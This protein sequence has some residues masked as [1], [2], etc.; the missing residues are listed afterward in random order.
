MFRRS[1]PRLLQLSTRT[2]PPNSPP[3]PRTLVVLHGL[4]G[5]SQN[6]LSPTKSIL[7]ELGPEWSAVLLDIRGHGT[8]PPGSP[9]TILDAASDV[10]STLTSLSISPTAV[11]GHSLGGKIALQYLSISPSPPLKTWSLDSF[12][13]PLPRPPPIPGDN[14]VASILSAV[15]TCPRTFSSKSDLI[16]TLTED[17]LLQPSIAMWM[18]TNLKRFETGRFE[19]TFDVE[20]CNNLYD[21]FTV[22]DLTDVLRDSQEDVTLLKAERNEV[23]EGIEEERLTGGNERVKVRTLE[24]SGHWVHVDNPKRLVEMICEDLKSI[25]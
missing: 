11:I 14:S 4:L 21:S 8:S 15:S 20:T 9:C 7:K 12:P 18:T 25:P 19:F 22:E 2:L 6:F 13:L 10:H 1:L 16:K 5:S 23:W 24:D 17:H 3:T